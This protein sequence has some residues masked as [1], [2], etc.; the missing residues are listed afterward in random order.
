MKKNII[1]VLSVALIFFSAYA[2]EPTDDNP[3]YMQYPEEYE[4]FKLRGKI[5]SNFDCLPHDI[6]NLIRPYV[7]QT[8]STKFNHALLNHNY[9]QKRI[10]R[11]QKTINQHEEHGFHTMAAHARANLQP[12]VEPE[13]NN[14]LKLTDLKRETDKI[15]QYH[16]GTYA[17]VPDIGC[18]YAMWD[19][20]LEQKKVIPL[21]IPKKGEYK[22]I[23]SGSNQKY[24]DF[25]LW[26]PKEEYID[27]NK[28]TLRVISKSL[29]E[30]I[31]TFSLPLSLQFTHAVMGKDCSWLALAL[32]NNHLYLLNVETEKQN[33]CDLKDPIDSLIAGH[34]SP[35]FLACGKSSAVLYLGKTK[36]VIFEYDSFDTP[37]HAVMS[38]DDR[39]FIIYGGKI[40]RLYIKDMK[41]INDHHFRKG[42]TI[43]RANIARG[44]FSPDSKR[45]VLAL[46]NGSLLL[47]DSLSGKNITLHP[48]TW[49]VS[50]SHNKPPL[51]LYS[52]KNKLL[53]SLDPVP[54]QNEEVCTFIIRSLK[55]GRLL[56]R[57]NFY[58]T[59]PCAMGLKEN[60][61]SVVFVLPDATVSELNL[62]TDQD[63]KDI[64]FIENKANIY[65]LGVL[66][67]LYK[68]YKPTVKKDVICN[69][70]STPL[71]MAMRDYIK[72]KSAHE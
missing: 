28:H 9:Q 45:I 61:Q 53:I 20:T 12:I 25:S 36:S 24:G 32:S 57:Y 3:M 10:Y 68:K 42:E 33:S 34:Q 62:Y 72:K 71:V 6:F 58:P 31:D 65:E 30:K 7:A 11:L 22:L 56:T 60:E 21:I 37:P 70:N 17:K 23:L 8:V 50:F 59:S 39:V 16:D 2:M 69:P 55:S 29:N 41:N 66:L 5:K 15:F 44:S 35:A 13:V 67:S 51:F 40:L 18:D 4:S 1:L 54:N 19:E 48:M 38:P 27:N 49:A 63:M 52:L 26:C 47:F 43:L 64:D 14:I 46:E